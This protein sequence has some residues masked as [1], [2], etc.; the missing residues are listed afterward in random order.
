MSRIEDKF[1]DVRLQNFSEENGKFY[2][3]AQALTKDFECETGLN[4]LAKDGIRQAITYRHRHPIQKEHK[5]AHIFGR[6]VDAHVG[7]SLIIKA[8]MYDHTQDHRDMIEIIKKRDFVNDPMGWSMHYRTYFNEEGKKYHWDVFEIAGTPIPACEKCKTISFGVETMANENKDPNQKEDKE[9]DELEGAKEMEKA[10]KTIKELEARLNAKTE[11]LEGLKTKI[12]KLESNI[13]VK[14][15]ELEEKGQESKSL[16]DRVLEMESTIK[17][18]SEKKPVID[19]ILEANPEIDEHELKWLKSMDVDYLKTKL[20]K[21]RKRSVSQIQTQELEDSAKK[22][23][24]LK[25]KEEKEFEEKEK[26]VTYEQ[27]TSQLE[28]KKKK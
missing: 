10:L 9:D 15:K 13:K 14:D 12:E 11:S 25:T 20:E 4:A 26:S 22:A 19:G 23:K 8:E 5:N 17:Y 21:E 6:V 24:A 7:D 28:F 1:T 18:L 16:E 3:V 27:F 2:V